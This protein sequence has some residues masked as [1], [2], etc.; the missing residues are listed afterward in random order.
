MILLILVINTLVLMAW[1]KYLNH[2]DAFASDK[3]NEHRLF[4]LVIT[5]GIPSIILT[6]MVQ[7]HWESILFNTTGLHSNM[8]PFVEELLIVGPVEEFSKFIIFIVLTGMMKSIKEPRDGILQAAS[9]AMGFA[10]V[11]NIIYAFRYGYTV[12]IV[13]SFLTILGHM[14]YAVIWGFTWGATAYTSAGTNKTTD[15]YIIIPSLILAALFHGTYNALLDYGYP[16]FAIIV[17]LTT[18]SLFFIIYNYVKDNSPYKSYKLKEY[19]KAIPELKKGL[20]KYPDSYVL[21]KRMGV[22]NIYAKSYNK[23]SKYLNKARKIKPKNS[24][25]RF[26]YGV[27]K[28][29]DGETE[30]GLK[31]MNTAIEALPVDM[32]KRMVAT[33]NNVVSTELGRKELL[34][35]ISSTTGLFE[36]NKHIEKRGNNRAR[37]N[38]QSGTQKRRTAEQRRI[39][40]AIAERE[41][42]SYK[43]TSINRRIQPDTF[44]G[45]SSWDSMFKEHPDPVIRE[46]YY[47]KKG[48][49]VVSKTNKINKKVLD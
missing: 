25:A 35:K 2:L 34:N 45:R 13:R 44:G 38:P 16:L 30:K 23:A 31:D 32:R 21:N 41:E 47:L 9:V 12:L 14:S 6:F 36:T 8:N 5:G 22:F 24:A 33:I 42:R 19:R 20:Q 46:P 28:Y 37:N 17:N 15:R 40:R 29:M 7:S 1:G 43:K 11:E 26:Y 27:S 18:M 10:L 48:E 39:V 3:K 49:S 4:W